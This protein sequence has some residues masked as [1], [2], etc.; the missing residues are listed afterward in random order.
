MRHQQRTHAQQHAHIANTVVR[1][2]EI[3]KY[4]QV[5][6]QMKEKFNMLPLAKWAALFAESNCI[7]RSQ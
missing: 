1:E 3:K 7:F 5:H 4:E 6:E 2:N